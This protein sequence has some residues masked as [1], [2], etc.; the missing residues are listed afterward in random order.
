MAL[1]AGGALDLRWA[2]APET[3]LAAPPAVDSTTAY[4]PLS[5]AEVVALDL[6]TG[7]V[8]WRAPVASTLSPAIGAEI[9]YVATADGVSAL[10]AASGSVLWHRQLPG[11]IAA[12]L[13][14]DTGW[15]VA[16]FES[17]DLAAMRASDGELLWRHALG[18]V[19]RVAPAPG[20]AN[21]YLGTVD[22]RLVALD[23]A[24]GRPVWSR[25]LDAGASGLTV[26]DDALVVGTTGRYLYNLAL[27]SGRVRWRWRIGAPVAGAAA[28]D[29]R[30][31]YVAAF[32]H[33][34]RAL[35][36][37]SGNLRWR[38]ALPHR[39]A[40]SP[41]V[42]GATVLVPSLSTELSAYDAAT[43]AP[44]LS[45]ASTGEV[46]GEVYFRVGGSPRG[47]R[48]LAVTVERRLLA[49][50]PRVEPQTTPLGELPGA[51]IVEPP[52]RPAPGQAAGSVS[53]NAWRYR[54][55]YASVAV[56]PTN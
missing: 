47:T 14:W 17:G 19:V 49:Y 27:D 29:A 12:P 39:P 8:R 38:R 52:R 45:L 28:A 50:G 55:M 7:R 48:L 11:T 3:L 26:V 36:R 23:L 56:S 4:A 33:V 54:W 22:G 46:A 2:T 25:A 37:R 18:A 9:V 31:L 21:L 20:L 53:A 24:T 5:T 44:G 41:V 13:Y 32:D 10:S 30:H 51:T 6:D 40:G 42:I 15:L 35:D 43:G 34:L 1:L 16:S